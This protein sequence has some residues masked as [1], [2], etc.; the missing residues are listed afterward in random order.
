MSTWRTPLTNHIRNKIKITTL[1]H[2]IQCPCPMLRLLGRKLIVLLNLEGGQFLKRTLNF[3]CYCQPIKIL[4]PWKKCRWHV[5]LHQNIDP[6]C[7]L[8][9]FFVFLDTSIN[10]VMIL[11]FQYKLP[12]Y[13]NNYIFSTLYQTSTTWSCDT[14][15]NLLLTDLIYSICIG[16]IVVVIV[17]Q[18]DL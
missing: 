2:V 9:K 4:Q 12:T 3:I 18:L 8:T 14:S 5:F 15:I 7:K 1:L 13:I 17:W 11:V 16:A 10:C 6:S